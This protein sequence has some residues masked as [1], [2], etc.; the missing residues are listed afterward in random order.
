MPVLSG[1]LAAVSR[2]LDVMG[3]LLL[4]LAL[5]LRAVAAQTQTPCTN[6]T[7]YAITELNLRQDPS[8]DAAVLRFVPK[9]AGVTRTTGAE[10]NG[11]APVI[12]DSVPGWVVALGLVATPEEVEEAS[13]PVTPAPTPAPPAT[14]ENTRV[15]LSALLLRSGPSVDAE[16]ILTMPDGATLTL[17][18]VGAENGYVT[19]EY[20]GVTGWAYADLL[21]RPGEVA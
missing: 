12:Y 16:P 6:C 14:T 13:V 2:T 1:R 19:V 10:M 21:A 4:A 20:D 3:A 8:L 11:Y 17:T 18:R 7:L 9:G 5:D 15:T